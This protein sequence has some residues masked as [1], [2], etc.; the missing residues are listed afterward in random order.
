MDNIFYMNSRQNMSYDIPQLIMAEYFGTLEKR[1]KLSRKVS[2]NM[3]VNRTVRFDIKSSEDS[4][5]I[6]DISVV[7]D[8]RNIN[9]YGFF[10]MT[11]DKLK[12]ELY[13]TLHDAAYVIYIGKKIFK[14]FDRGEIA[15]F[16]AHELAH[17][18]NGDV[19][20]DEKL[21][22]AASQRLQ[23]QP[24]SEIEITADV[25]A[26]FASSEDMYIQAFRKLLAFSKCSVVMAAFQYGIKY[27][28]FFKSLH[29][30]FRTP[31]IIEEI[32]ADRF[33]RAINKYR[34]LKF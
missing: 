21:I 16:I 30:L 26:I 24:E 17:I 15:V 27:K 29:R 1:N 12:S 14:K 9:T 20:N 7:V 25:A 19:D 6:Y 22:D 11:A 34:M 10:S 4:D 8:F 5:K 28:G 32:F 23:L 18:T 3:C 33:S 31:H 2:K 13:I